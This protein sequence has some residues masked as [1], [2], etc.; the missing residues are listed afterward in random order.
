MEFSSQVATPGQFP[1]QI[2]YQREEKHQCGG[3]IL[4]AET[5]LTAAHCCVK[6]DNFAVVSLL[7]GEF[8]LFVKEGS[9]QVNIPN[10]PG[11]GEE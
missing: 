6:L 1:H 7:A 8:D 3:S 2:S 5:V 10:T 4:D 11:F 9:E